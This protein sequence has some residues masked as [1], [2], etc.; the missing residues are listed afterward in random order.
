MK[1]SLV[2]LVLGATVGPLAAQTRVTLGASVVS[3][4]VRNELPVGGGAL[5][6]V[7]FGGDGELSVGRWLLAVT[8][9]QGTVHPDSGSTPARDLV[10]GGA[11]IGFRPLGWLTLEAGPRGRTYV[12]TSGTQRWLFW[13]LRARAEETFIGSGVKGYAELWRAASANVSVP[14]PLDHAQGGEAGMTVRVSRMLEARVAYR[15]DHAVLGGGS[16]RETVDG[17]VV[18]VGL[19]RR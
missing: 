10:E 7:A 3:V 17:I 5:S 8:Y 1:P 13:E 9:H 16:R 18:G 14:E 19:A 4:R 12:F 2:F 11:A 6:G 15:I